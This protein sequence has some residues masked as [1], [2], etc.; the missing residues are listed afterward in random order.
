MDSEVEE[1]SSSS[2]LAV[3]GKLEVVEGVVVA[4]LILEEKN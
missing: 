2:V 3:L 1:S 4:V